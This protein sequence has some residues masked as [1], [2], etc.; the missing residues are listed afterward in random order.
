VASVVEMRDMAMEGL[1]DEVNEVVLEVKTES[2]SVRKMARDPLG[3]IAPGALR[4]LAS[5][6]LKNLKKWK[7]KSYPSWEA[8]SI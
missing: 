1:K 2:Q 5:I 8:W 4:T 7:S 3:M 6:L